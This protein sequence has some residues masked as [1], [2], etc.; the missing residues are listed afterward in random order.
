MP[1][2]DTDAPV[3]TVPQDI[4]EP[5]GS[6]LADHVYFVSLAELFPEA[7]S[8]AD[9]FDN[10]ADFRSKIRTATRKDLFEPNPRLSKEKNELLLSPGSSLEGRWK[11]DSTGSKVCSFLTRVFQEYGFFSLEGHIFIERI[12]S[13]CCSGGLLPRV[14]AERNRFRVSGSWLDIVSPPG[15]RSRGNHAWHQDSG[16]HQFTTML[17]FPKSDNYVGPGVFSH[18]VKLSHC[19]IPPERPGPVI[20]SGSFPEST[21]IRPVYRKGREIMVYKDSS[22]VHSAP[23]AFIRDGVWRFM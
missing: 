10:D 16:L 20:I 5:P 19:M 3:F 14:D 21:I 4:R 15:Q 9:L 18:V 13:L 7:P 11:F 23:D 22:V 8:F 2:M 6:L 17:G 12:G 1:E